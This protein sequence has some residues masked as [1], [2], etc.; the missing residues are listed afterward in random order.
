MSDSTTGMGTRRSAIAIVQDGSKLKA[1]ELSRQ[2]GIFEVL[3]TNSSEAGDLDWKAFELE[4]SLADEQ[5][6]KVE[7]A[8]GRTVVGH[9]R[10]GRLRDRFAVCG[11]FVQVGV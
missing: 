5:T 8:D 9:H 6:K 7:A 1:V 2:R 10:F 11:Q 4:C 3:W